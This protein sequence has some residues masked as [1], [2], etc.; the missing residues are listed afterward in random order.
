MTSLTFNGRV[1]SGKSEAARFIAL[2]W[3]ASQIEKKLGFAAYPGT[4]NIK[5]SRSETV[6]LERLKKARTMEIA[7]A[8]GFC[9]GKLFKARIDNSVQCAVVIPEVESYPQDV[10][11]VI[12][13]TNLRQRLM[14]KDGDSVKV[15]VLLG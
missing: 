14:L 4:L 12:A 13:S 2:P 8:E 3:V 9:R 11:E 10:L 1:S 15:T 5:L 7:P 6:K